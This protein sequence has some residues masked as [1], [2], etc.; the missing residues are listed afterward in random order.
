MVVVSSTLLNSEKMSV[1][2][3]LEQLGGDLLV[4]ESRDQC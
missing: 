3:K 4:R 1:S 2:R